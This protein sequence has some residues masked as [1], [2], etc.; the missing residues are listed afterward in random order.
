MLDWY[1]NSNGN[2][3]HSISKGDV[4]TVYKK[5]DGE[6]AGIYD[7][8]FLRGSYDNPE[9]AQIRMERWIIDGDN[10][11]EAPKPKLGWQPA[12]KGGFYKKAAGGL[13]TVKQAKTGKWFI[14][15]NSNMV[16]GVWL[17]TQEEAM[18]RANEYVEYL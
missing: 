10:S 6:W 18:K 4:M 15:I 7:G 11:L 8:R 17:N 14:T 1:E 3:V 9:E 16:E 2:Y 13:A 5:Q 12:K